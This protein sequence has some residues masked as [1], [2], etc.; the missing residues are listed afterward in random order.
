MSWTTAGS[1]GVTTIRMDGDWTVNK[2]KLDLHRIIKHC[3]NLGIK[4][5]I[6]FE[7]EMVNY[8]SDLYKAHPEYALCDDGED[9]HVMRHQFHLDFSNP[10]AIDAI[11]K[12]IK[13]FLKEY[14]IDYIKW[15]YNR[16]VYEHSST[17]LGEKRQ[18]EVYHRITLGYYSL[19]SRIAKDNPKIMIEG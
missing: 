18:G 5:G 6:W 17:R 15:D 14:E 9:I 2:S 13:T 3:H 4:F 8:N 16:R 12:Q 11:Y 19:I 10:Q 7:S 1:D